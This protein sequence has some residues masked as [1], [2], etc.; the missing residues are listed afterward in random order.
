M[1]YKKADYK[2]LTKTLI[3]DGAVLYDR[4]CLWFT[5]YSVVVLTGTSI[6]SL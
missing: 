2:K 3:C 1:A 5:L 6:V 4:R